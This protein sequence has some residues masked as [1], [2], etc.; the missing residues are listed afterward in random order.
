MKK[1]LIYRH[2]SLGDFIISLPAIKMIR[3]QNPKSKI[4]LASLKKKTTGF[5]TPNLVPLRKNIINNY[6]FCEYNILSIVK[7]FRIIVKKKFDKIY[8]LNEISSNLRLKR[9]LLIFN[10]LGI[11]EKYGFIPEQ[12]NYKNF[13]ETYYLCKRVKEKVKKNEI[14]FFNIVQKNKDYKK[15][16]FITISLGGRNIKKKWKIKNWEILI[17][18][19]LNHFPNLNIKIIGSKNEKF[20]SEKICKINKKK[21]INMCGKTNI[22]TLFN[23][24]NHSK[25]HLSHDDGTMHV[26]SI[27]KK[28]GTAIFGIT[29]D[30]GRFFPSNVKQRIFYPKKDIN[31]INPHKVFKAIFYD[32]KNLR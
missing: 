5:I 10:L 7:F 23:L 15:K 8:Y 1:I 20:P 25:Y 29:S 3:D 19:I 4:Y 22:N 9:D 11:K 14:S 27:F 30:K 26:A 2:C 24:I 12:Y 13:N 17:K 31:E 21:I 16:K 28:C 6:I 32:L 18:K